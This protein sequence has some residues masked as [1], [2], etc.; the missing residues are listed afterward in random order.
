MAHVPDHGLSIS[1]TGQAA[2]LAECVAAYL[3]ETLK[4]SGLSL[5]AFELLSAVRAS[6]SSTQ[7]EL[8]A[9]LGITPSSLC[10]AVRAALGRGFV[11]Q[12]GSSTDRRAKRVVLTRNGAM[13]LEGSLA[14]LEK[15]ELLATDG[16]AA[17]RLN[18][19]VGVIR[20][21]A[22]NLSRQIPRP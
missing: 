18:M 16:I 11:E 6:P 22:K 1:V 8:A 20:Q 21:A 2:V 15:A 3:E 12:E 5:G 7:A 10:E 9:K 19:A 17:N 13:A 4:G 14:A